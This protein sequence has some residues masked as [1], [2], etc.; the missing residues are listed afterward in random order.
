MVNEKKVSE[1]ELEPLINYYNE[2]QEKITNLINVLIQQVQ[3]YYL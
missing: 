2:N 1:Q 3:V